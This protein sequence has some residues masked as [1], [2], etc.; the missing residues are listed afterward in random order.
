MYSRW[1]NGSH[2]TSKVRR[3]QTGTVSCRAHS[4]AR[5]TNATKGTAGKPQQ[6]AWP[7]AS[8]TAPTWLASNTGPYMIPKSLISCLAVVTWGP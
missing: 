1:C 4:S 8:R 5:E 6:R 2:D 3:N 7:T